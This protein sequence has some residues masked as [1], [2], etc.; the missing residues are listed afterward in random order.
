MGV[1]DCLIDEG[2]EPKIGME[3][4]F[5]NNT[6]TPVQDGCKLRCGGSFD[7][8]DGIIVIDVVTEIRSGRHAGYSF[9][10]KETGE[11]YY[12]TYPWAFWENTPENLVKIKK[13]K[14]ENSKLEEQEKLV[15]GLR[16]GI[17]QWTVK[18]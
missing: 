4:F 17:E 7:V 12:S 16:K 9:T 14:E 11:R 5:M 2:K 18:K 10:I 3:Y 1:F 13:Y 15:K 6:A 8:E